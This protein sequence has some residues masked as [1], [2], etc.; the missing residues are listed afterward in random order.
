MIIYKW[1]RSLE[2]WQQFLILI[3][4]IFMLLHLI[5]LVDSITIYRKTGHN[6]CS[7]G[8]GGASPCS[9]WQGYNSAFEL[10]IYI[11]F[12]PLIIL[13]SLIFGVLKLI[14]IFR[15]KR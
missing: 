7:M 12:L 13:L 8:F 5:T 10:L 11:A 3:L 1:W 2:Y 14:S 15:E 4:I 6:Y 9:F